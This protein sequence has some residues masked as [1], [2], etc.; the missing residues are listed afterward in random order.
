MVSMPKYLWEDVSA[1]WARN[2]YPNLNTS[3]CPYSHVRKPWILV[4]RVSGIWRFEFFQVFGQEHEI[5]MMPR[6]HFWR[7]GWGRSFRKERKLSFSLKYHLLRKQQTHTRLSTYQLVPFNVWYISP[8]MGEWKYLRQVS[9]TIMSAHIT[10]YWA[11]RWVPTFAMS[12]LCQ[13]WGPITLGQHLIRLPDR[14]CPKS[15]SLSWQYSFFWFSSQVLKGMWSCG[16]E[17]VQTDLN[18]MECSWNLGWPLIELI[19]LQFIFQFLWR[20]FQNCLSP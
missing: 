8:L 10:T 15:W 11:W 12:A 3:C 16:R 6:W 1:L 19:C 2:F 18:N 5:G 14:H 13:I 17:F 20:S 4:S 9:S 7:T